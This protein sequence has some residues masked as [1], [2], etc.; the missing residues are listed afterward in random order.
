MSHKRSLGSMALNDRFRTLSG[1]TRRKSRHSGS[2]VRFPAQSGR[3]GRYIGR[4]AFSQ[5]A[6]YWHPSVG[7]RE[8][9][10]SAGHSVST[11]PF[12]VE[13]VRSLARFVRPE[14]DTRSAS[15][16]TQ[17]ELAARAA[18]SFSIGN[19]TSPMSFRDFTGAGFRSIIVT[20]NPSKLR[21]GRNAY[22]QHLAHLS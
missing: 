1:R 3:S 10:F 20:S 12:P 18:I 6:T 19:T 13:R 5:K 11:I 16:W 21:F 4:S 8:C 14:S 7:A 17:D 15:M 22:F 9:A 2:D